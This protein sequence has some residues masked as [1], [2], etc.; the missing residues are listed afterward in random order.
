MTLP[1]RFEKISAILDEIENELRNFKPLC[2]SKKSKK[3][4]LFK[5]IRR[6]TKEKTILAH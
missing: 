4:T 3:V 5:K 2:D 6:Q 1:D